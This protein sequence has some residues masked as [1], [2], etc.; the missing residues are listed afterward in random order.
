MVR[1]IFT[2]I[3]FFVCSCILFGQNASLNTKMLS[4]VQF[5]GDNSDV[6]GYQKDGIN[7]AIIGNAK[8][9][10]IFSLED[11]SN[12]KL[13][14]EASGAQSIWRDIK[15][16]NNHLYVTTDQGQDGLVIID[17]TN[18]PTT[19]SHIYF[20]PE[21][22]VGDISNILR[23]CHNLYIDENGICYLSGCNI[24]QG[25]VLMF[26]LKQ[27]PNSPTYLGIADQAY[28]HDA[29]ARG[30]TLYSSEVNIG[31]LTIY[32]VK[33]KANPIE[34]ATQATSRNFAHN[35][36]PSDDGKYV[37][38]TDEK[39][40]AYVDAYDIT[41]LPDIK[42]IDRFR[43]LERENDNVIPHNTHYYQGYLVT[44][45]YTDGVRI[46]DAHKPDN[47][48]EV[49]YYD[50]W[51]DP[52]SCHS[53]FFGCWGAFPFTGTNIL[54]ASDINN[55]LFI[56]EVDY[57]RACYLEGIVKDTDGIAI[58][59]AKIEILSDQMNRE[60]S[61]P[62]GEYKT[63][64]AYDGSYQVQIT[65]PDFVTQIITVNFA[66]GEVTELNPILIRKRPIE[67]AFDL[68]G[69]DGEGV[70]ASILL[71]NNS[72]SY[73][74]K[75]N[76]G[77]L[78]NQ[79]VL[80]ADYELF[81]N[82]W[83]YESIYEPSFTIG[84]GADNELI[85]NVKKGY[86]DNFEINLNW[87]VVSTANM[88]GE[89]ERVKPRLT[90]FGNI[91]ANPGKDSDDAG[92]IAYVTGNGT[93]GAACDDVDNGTTRL[94]SPA[95][96]LSSFNLPKLNYDVWFF[97]AGG[98]STINDTL[99]IKLT[100]GNREVVVDK[101]FGNTGGWKAIREVD[102][103]GFISKKDNVKL[104]VEASDLP[105]SGHLVEAG[106]D[107]F[108]ISQSASSSED[109]LLFNNEVHIYPNPANDRLVIEFGDKRNI[110]LHK[111]RI[112]NTLGSVAKEGTIDF[113]TSIID[114]ST[115]PLGLYLIEIT[116][117][118]PVKFIKN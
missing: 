48:I 22:V 65:H 4:Q 90:K 57:K 32:D 98:S 92:N 25:G 42:L 26:D 55:G 40:G 101:I 36:W 18:A 116:G 99:V 1:V 115:L 31:R 95:M 23:K 54:Y 61:S 58:P 89:W 39:G 49:A 82:A 15:S 6:W 76:A 53:G 59:N 110:D 112:I 37:F 38:T 13:R 105:N 52:S 41:E 5:Q 81:V 56:I 96:D 109:F 87:N 50:T 72:K 51:E 60:L 24:S 43:P 35:A 113:H 10:S 75:T 111:Y 46:I 91:N 20:K 74:L 84:E 118:K 114:I 93:P 66:R 29:F 16:Y 88:S 94:I 73:N 78:L 100:D 117:K 45:W 62:S 77:G 47:L 2:F 103:D 63:G 106:F 97:N 85:R 27:N 17:M 67:V 83:G 3:S 11:P 7:Y 108:F 107:N 69:V 34:L 12:P 68:K 71:S 19:I 64:S 86:S 80:A 79:T 104:I 8:K 102:I 44:S 33:D 28:S 30:D 21:I 70:S 9:T 14:Y